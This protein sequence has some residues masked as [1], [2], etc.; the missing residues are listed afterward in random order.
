MQINQESVFCRMH[1][2]FVILLV[3]ALLSACGDGGMSDL[4][5][6]VDTAYQDKKPEI[7]PLPPFEPYKAFQYPNDEE[8]DPFSF[9]N[10]VTNREGEAAALGER[11]DSNR[12]KEHLE[13]FPLDALS[14][15]GTMTQQGVPWV[16]VKTTQGT[17]H[18]ATIGNYMGQND[19][20]IKNIY[21]EEERVEL[22]ETVPDPQ[23]RWVTRQVE[24][25]IDE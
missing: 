19:G 4:R 20:K 25:S 11:P 8:I 12:E 1:K 21:P 24:I 18:L 3:A 2:W 7:D 22:I 13:S 10:I 17:A 16:I 14:M 15:V 6:F 5:E 23:G 9:E